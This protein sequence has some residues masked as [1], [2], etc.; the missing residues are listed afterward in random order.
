MLKISTIPSSATH[1]EYQVEIHGFAD[2]SNE[3]GQ[4]SSK[5]NV[6]DMQYDKNRKLSDDDYCNGFEC[7][8]F[9][10][11]IQLLLERV[12]N[13]F[14]TPSYHSLYMNI[15]FNGNDIEEEY[16]ELKKETIKNK[17]LLSKKEYAEWCEFV[18]EEI[19]RKEYLFNTIKSL[20]DGI[21]G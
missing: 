20:V 11:G 4:I 1:G 7:S 21:L 6:V 14:Y 5:F 9:E 12:K 19:F 13:K 15:I 2:D 16:E 8:S 18:L 3:G 17:S 10:E